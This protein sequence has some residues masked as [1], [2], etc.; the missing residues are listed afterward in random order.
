MP[1]AFNADLTRDD[2]DAELK[3]DGQKVL[4]MMK[5]QEQELD[6][7][8]RKQTLSELQQFLFDN[9]LTAVMLPVASAQN[10]GFSKRLQDVN[11]ADWP[12]YYAYRRQST[13]LKG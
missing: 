2:L 13:W 9:A 1:L 3:A 10:L 5:K 4:E 8:V 11:Y 6:V 7:N 12:S